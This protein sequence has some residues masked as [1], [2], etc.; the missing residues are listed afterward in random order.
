MESKLKFL[1]AQNYPI[2]ENLGGKMKYLLIL[3][4][5]FLLLFISCS[6]NIINPSEDDLLTSKIIGT[7]KDNQNY[8]ITF[9]NNNTFKD[10]IY[11]DSNPDTSANNY[12]LFIRKGKYSIS[13]SVL[14]L[15]EFNIDTIITNSMIG[16]GMNSTHSEISIINNQLRM[17][18][19]LIF[20]KPDNY[21]SDLWGEWTN[22]GWY[23]QRDADT[24]LYK[25]IYGPTVEKYIFYKDSS[26]CT[27]SKSTHNLYNDSTYTYTANWDYSYTPPYL[28]IPAPAYYNLKVKFG[29]SKMHW[30]FDVP[31]WILNKMN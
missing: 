10:S 21:V 12:G 1:H 15:T 16:M 20:Y 11:F 27:H 9:Y 13:N 5:P 23:C 30:Y 6:E 26:F 29:S 18:P 14:E 24:T 8:S 3:L 25:P 28:D 2:I 31:V 7:W 22:T 17:I 4:V 19:L